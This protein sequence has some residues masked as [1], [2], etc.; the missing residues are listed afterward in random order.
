MNLTYQEARRSKLL[1]DLKWERVSRDILATIGTIT[2]LAELVL[3]KEPGWA[4]ALALISL[5]I[6]GT[7]ISS[8]KKIKQINES[9][10]SPS[11]RV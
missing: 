7:A 5:G 10:N 8:Y 1:E 3:L 6:V 9:A 11:L 4:G 2:A